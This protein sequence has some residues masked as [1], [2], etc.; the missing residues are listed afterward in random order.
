MTQLKKHLLTLMLLLLP[1]A[2][3]SQGSL[4]KQYA[5]R[6]DLKVGEVDG[7]K[8][9]DSVRVDVVMLQA[10]GCRLATPLRGIRHQR[11]ADVGELAGIADQSGATRQVDR[12]T[13]AACDSLP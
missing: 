10:E 7:F 12:Q 6:S 8:L 3:M 13:R 1:V 2:A 5:Q 11:Y 9:N 4:Y